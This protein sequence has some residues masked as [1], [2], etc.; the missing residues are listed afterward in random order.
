MT[1]Q[2]HQQNKREV[3]R[4]EAYLSSRESYYIC[5]KNECADLTTTA[6]HKIAKNN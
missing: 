1:L 2:V 4:E 3:I 5:D 6:L